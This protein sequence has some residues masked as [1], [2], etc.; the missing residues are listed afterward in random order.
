MCISELYL[1]CHV[2]LL[3]DDQL[4]RGWLDWNKRISQRKEVHCI[5]LCYAYAAN[6]SLQLGHGCLGFFQK[7]TVQACILPKSSI[8]H[9]PP[10]IYTGQ[11]ACLH[12]GLLQKH[13]VKPWQLLRVLFCRPA[14]CHSFRV[15]LKQLPHPKSGFRVR[16]SEKVALVSTSFIHVIIEQFFP[17]LS[18]PFSYL[19]FN[20]F[21]HLRLAGRS[22]HCC[23]RDGL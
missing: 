11:N 9:Q 12:N 14:N 19:T 21:L 18:H 16:K 6:S 22:A 3:Q 4:S 10:P 15:K 2:G 8:N 13:P 23:S 1:F 5:M 20:Q 7:A 17:K